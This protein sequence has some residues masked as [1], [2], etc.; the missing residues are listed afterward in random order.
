VQYSQYDQALAILASLAYKNGAKNE[1]KDLIFNPVSTYDLIGKPVLSELAARG[2]T[3]AESSYA[4]LSTYT[5]EKGKPCWFSVADEQKKVVYVVIRG[6]QDP[7][8]VLS[9][10][11]I[12]TKD[13]T[14]CG[15]EAKVHSGLQYNE[16]L[17]PLQ[18]NHMLL[19]LPLAVVFI[20]SISVSGIN[21][22]ALFVIEDSKPHIA[23]FLS[24][25]FS[26]VFTG[27]SLG[28]GTA[29][30]A[31]AHARTAGG[32]GYGDATA[33]TFACPGIVAAKNSDGSKSA[34]SK[35]LKKFVTTYILGYDIV[36]RAAGVAVFKLLDNI[37]SNDWKEKTKK[38]L[39]EEAKKKLGANAG[40]L[41]G[42]MAKMS[43]AMPEP[44]AEEK[45]A[46]AAKV[47]KVL[48]DIA[49]GVLP[50][51]YCFV[52]STHLTPCSQPQAAKR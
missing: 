2:L 1:I 19:R 50:W 16:T 44:T 23:A 12:Q 26:L 21:D 47:K 15:H 5:S 35:A 39:A 25:G 14:I 34:A 38:R 7:A 4:Q 9:D 45:A 11:N 31:A 8:D 10:L 20:R 41:G 37:F 32:Q 18:Y 22:S 46:E 28:A 51:C 29:A 43:A 27:H 40:M 48:D 17:N 24:Q 52:L 30:L 42:A 6:T 33:V 49:E 36:P 13:I 3:L